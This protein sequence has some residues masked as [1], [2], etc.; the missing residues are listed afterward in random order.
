MAWKVFF[1][2]FEDCVHERALYI[3]PQGTGTLKRDSKASPLSSCHV[4][5]CTSYN[6]VIV[7]IILLLHLRP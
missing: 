4:A 1:M 2:Y 7:A 6:D 3:A 5:A